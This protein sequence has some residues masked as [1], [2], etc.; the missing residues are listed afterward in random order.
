MVE[1]LLF[2]RGEFQSTG[3]TKATEMQRP[4]TVTLDANLSEEALT[5]V[6]PYDLTS[7]C[8]FSGSAVLAAAWK[9]H[10]DKRLQ[11][12]LLRPPSADPVQFLTSDSENDMPNW[13]P[14]ANATTFVRFPGSTRTPRGR[15]RYRPYAT[16][17]LGPSSLMCVDDALAVREFIHRDDSEL[18]DP[19][20]SPDGASIAFVERRF[21]TGGELVVAIR[22]LGVESG[23]VSTVWED[24]NVGL[25]SP[26]WNPTADRLLFERTSGRNEIL[27][28]GRQ[29]GTP[30][31]VIGNGGMPAMSADG[32]LA[33]CRGGST[34]EAPIS[35]F[36]LEPGAS[37]P[38]K[39][40]RGLDISARDY[41][42]CWWVG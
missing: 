38:T 13:S 9:D 14:S 30:E 29:G 31:L 15:R 3:A 35:I 6:L 34:A 26:T 27:S 19:I 21:G 16:A 20:W 41:K 33:F 2:V 24:R 4:W 1:R 25:W 42:P 8:W 5:A 7:A 22:V 36:L 40:T 18:F 37:E 23:E 10:P 11:L 32:R 39:L 12:Y 17:V 28:V